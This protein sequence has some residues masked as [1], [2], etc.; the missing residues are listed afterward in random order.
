MHHIQMDSTRLLGKFKDHQYQ[1]QSKRCYL[2]KCQNWLYSGVLHGSSYDGYQFC[3]LVCSLG[4]PLNVE[5]ESLYLSYYMLHSCQLLV[6]LEYRKQ[7][8]NFRQLLD[9]MLN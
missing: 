6:H 5:C 3:A 1:L 8:Y 2:C 7:D 4:N 9:K